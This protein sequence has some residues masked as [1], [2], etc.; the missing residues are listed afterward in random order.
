[1][2]RNLNGLVIFALDELNR[3]QT[4]QDLLEI[5]LEQ[6]EEL[7][8]KRAARAELLVSS[9]VCQMEPHLDELR[10]LLERIRKL[11]KGDEIV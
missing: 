7:P 6:G 10:V 1:M 8:E 4:L 3:I 5:Y 9:Y 2:A 11:L